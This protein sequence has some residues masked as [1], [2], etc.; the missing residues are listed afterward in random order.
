LLE[1]LAEAEAAAA[2]SIARQQPCGLVEAAKA[3]CPA[4]TY[5]SRAN[6]RVYIKQRYCPAHLRDYTRAAL[7]VLAVMQVVLELVELRELDTARAMLKQT[8]VTRVHG[9]QLFAVFGAG[10]RSC[11]TPAVSLAAHTTIY[12]SLVCIIE[13][14]TTCTPPAYTHPLQPHVCMPCLLSAGAA[15]VEAGGP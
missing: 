13:A 12:L 2:D 10:I 6:R 5:V 3:H 8:Q 7:L 1:A 11:T 4:Y 15:A 9:S 14:H